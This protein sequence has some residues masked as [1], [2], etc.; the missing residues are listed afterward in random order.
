[1]ATIG[2]RYDA[3]QLQRVTMASSSAITGPTRLWICCFEE[4]YQTLRCGWNADNLDNDHVPPALRQRPS[5]QG[6]RSL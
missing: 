5:N 4:R 6:T 3:S 2:T 1:M